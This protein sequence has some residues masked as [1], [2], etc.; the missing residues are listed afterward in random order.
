MKTQNDSI[1]GL[2]EA[3]LDG[4]TMQD[5]MEAFRDVCYGKEIHVAENW[6]DYKLA[7]EWKTWARKFDNLAGVASRSQHP[8]FSK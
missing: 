6:Q 1:G 5:V 7:S 3:A 2:L 8:S 4:A